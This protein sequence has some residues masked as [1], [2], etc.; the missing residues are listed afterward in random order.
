MVEKKERAKLTSSAARPDDRSIIT[1]EKQQTAA[2]SCISHLLCGFDLVTYIYIDVL[3]C[4]TADEITLGGWPL[5]F[6]PLRCRFPSTA[7]FAVDYGDG[8]VDSNLGFVSGSKKQ[9]MSRM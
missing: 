4:S 3:P 9:T 2:L 1:K 6:M 8:D 5:R 7:D